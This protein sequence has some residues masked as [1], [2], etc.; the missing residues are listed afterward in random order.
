MNWHRAIRGNHRLL[1]QITRSPDPAERDHPIYMHFCAIVLADGT[2]RRTQLRSFAR[3]ARYRENVADRC[4]L[5]VS[6]FLRWAHTPGAAD[7]G[8]E[9]RMERPEGQLVGGSHS[10][11]FGASNARQH[12]LQPPLGSVAAS[13]LSSSAL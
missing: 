8:G 1:P 5:R 9:K 6:V 10:L 7:S 2:V 11:Y 13:G 4:R 3:A 12:G